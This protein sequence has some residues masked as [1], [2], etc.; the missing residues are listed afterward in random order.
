[1]GAHAERQE[2][3]DRAR[4]VE[5]VGVATELALVAVGRSVT[6]QHPVSCRERGATDGGVAL[7]D[8]A[9]PL[10]RR[11]EPEQL[12]DRV[13]NQ[14]R[15]VEQPLALVGV[16]GQQLGRTREQAGRRVVAARDHHERHAENPLEPDAVPFVVGADQIGHDV[17]AGCTAFRLDQPHEV[18]G[19]V[20]DRRRRGHARV[21]ARLHDRLR[22]LV[23]AEAVFLGH[24]QVVGDDPAR[25]RARQPRD[26][27]GAP[28]C[29][30]RPD[31]RADERPERGLECFDVARREP[32][33]H[34]APV[35]RVLGRIHEHHR[36]H[37]E[38][39]ALVVEREPVRRRERR[40][41]ARRVEH[42][43]EAREHPVAAGAAVDRVL[44]AQ[45]SVERVRI[46][47]R[48][49]PERPVLDG[50]HRGR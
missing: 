4:D 42:V 39:R 24:A 27:V 40:R 45:A 28:G 33:A 23:E 9:Q 20:G 21:V 7:R 3:V 50:G 16:T 36:L 49:A 15:I 6:E 35:A 18:G 5:L 30:E 29:P 48:V 2:A 11:R 14:R 37:A 34:E 19:Q 46:T 17:V 22:P 41:V 8:A 26:E 25:H 43:L 1:M 44:V 12:V 31:V 10:H 38:V 47:P 32:A 13:R